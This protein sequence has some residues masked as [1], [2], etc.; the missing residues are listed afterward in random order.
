MVERLLEA[1]ANVQLVDVRGYTALQCAAEGGH[2]GPFCCLLK[3]G[4]DPLAGDHAGVTVLQSA[5]QGGAVEIV[6]HLMQLGAQPLTK[7][8]LG[9]DALHY[10]ALGQCSEALH[11]ASV[12]YCVCHI[13]QMSD[14]LCEVHSMQC[15]LQCIQVSSRLL[16]RR[17]T[18]G[19]VPKLLEAAVCPVL[20]CNLCC[21]LKNIAR[22]RKNYGEPDRV[23]MKCKACSASCDICL[24]QICCWFLV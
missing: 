21:R 7:S 1:G 3:A 15:V 2:M 20:C 11:V 6:Q 5:C 12:G 23:C 22:F 16:T 13:L 17:H 14:F 18:T 8:L 9:R 24:L 19:K 4:C 10:A